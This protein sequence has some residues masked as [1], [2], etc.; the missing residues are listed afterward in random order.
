MPK[1][2][3]YIGVRY[4]KLVVLEKVS[5]KGE[6]YGKYKVECDCGKTKIVTGCNLQNGTTNSCGCIKGKSNIT[7]G[8]SGKRIYKIWLGVIERCTKEQYKAY[9]DYGGRGIKVCEKWQNS[10][11]KFYEDM[12]EGYSD[13]LTLDRID[14]NGGYYKENCRWADMKTQNR[15]RR[16]NLIVTIGQQSKLLKVWCE[17]Y[18]KDYNKVWLRIFR[19][20]W[21]PKKALET[22]FKNKHGKKY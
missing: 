18:E 17:E 7:H 10:F 16:K 12:E 21:E 11:E 6:K 3:N 2:V 20:Q 15:N 4:G 8:M 5:K 14:V 19:L 13:E 22:P 1:L 9:K